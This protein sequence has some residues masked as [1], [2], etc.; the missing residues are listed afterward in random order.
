M[1][2]F[3]VDVG[4]A[5][6]GG[7]PLEKGTFSLGLPYLSERGFEL[8]E[9]FAK[10]GFAE[11]FIGEPEIMK[12]HMHGFPKNGNNVKSFAIEHHGT[13]IRKVRR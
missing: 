6:G 13:R 3:R 4:S 11:L 12:T 1:E 2:A 9:K 10:G 5:Q 8:G 7:E